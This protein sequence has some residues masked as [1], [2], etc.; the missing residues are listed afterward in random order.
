[1]YHFSNIYKKN[2]IYEFRNKELNINLDDLNLFNY[3]FIE[4]R[5]RFQK[6]KDISVEKIKEIKINCN[7]LH[8]KIYDDLVKQTKDKKLIKFLKCIEFFSYKNLDETLNFF[9]QS[10]YFS[11]ICLKTS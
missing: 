9:L 3:N 10:K 5:S 8:K 11:N 4:L 2:K 6:K 7:I 1:M